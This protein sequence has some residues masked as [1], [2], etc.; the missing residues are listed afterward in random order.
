MIPEQNFEWPNCAKEYSLDEQRI[1][2]ALSHETYRWRAKDRLL[3]ATGLETDAF[4]TSLTELIR[5]GVVKPAF[6]P[7]RNIVFGLRERVDRK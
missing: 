7:K 2:Q 3:R 5:T 4:D 1:L 6:S